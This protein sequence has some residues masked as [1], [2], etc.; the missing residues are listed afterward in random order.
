VGFV[1]VESEMDVVAVDVVI[2]E[3]VPERRRVLRLG[4]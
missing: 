3:V 2:E 4:G 1:D